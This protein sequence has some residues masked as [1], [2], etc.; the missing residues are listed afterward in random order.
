MCLVGARVCARGRP[1]ARGGGSSSSLRR[2]VAW[3]PHPVILCTRT[4]GAHSMHP[5]PFVLSVP[6]P[7]LLTYTC[8]CP[9]RAA[10]SGA[11]GAAACTQP[12]R[13]LGT[14][15]KAVYI[16]IVVGVC[17]ARIGC[18]RCPALGS[19][20]SIPLALLSPSVVPSGDDIAVSR[21]A[22]PRRRRSHSP[23]HALH[24][25][26]PYVRCGRPASCPRPPQAES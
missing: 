8:V 24:A 7:H 21:A 4:R 25:R 17:G 11:L 3:R 1:G 6:Q 15:L 18:A 13:V 12:T 22:A 19:A 5:I 20:A 10:G 16:T 26:A 9:R 23:L 2:R 14:Y